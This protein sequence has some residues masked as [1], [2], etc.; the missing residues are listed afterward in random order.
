MI[1]YH[2]ITKM[3][4]NNKLSRSHHFY[5]WYG[6]HSQMDGLLLFY[7]HCILHIYMTVSTLVFDQSSGI[8]WVTCFY[9]VL[10]AACWIAMHKSGTQAP[11]QGFVGGPT[12]AGTVIL[13]VE[14]EDV[15]V[16]ITY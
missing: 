12:S 5:R 9:Y 7:Q 11:R 14:D 6:Y 10:I 13:D 3:W 1:L 15:W 16:W 2:E 4:V 8:G